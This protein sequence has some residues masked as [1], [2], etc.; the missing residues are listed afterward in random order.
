VPTPPP[1]APRPIP[2]SLAAAAA[3]FLIAGSLWPRFFVGGSESTSIEAG[4][5]RL[6]LCT[7][8]G[9]R[10]GGLDQLGQSSATWGKLG[11]AAAVLALLAAAGQIGLAM[12]A[13]RGRAAPWP[14]AAAFVG[15]LAL[16]LG[17]AFAATEPGLG[18]TLGPAAILYMVGAA[19]AITG[20]AWLH[21]AAAAPRDPA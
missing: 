15:M 21:R 2:T 4:L 12:S 16:A 6:S 20:G 18:L 9:C 3:A 17:V 8:S 1:T 14:R 19:L 7:D 13:A 11:M 10:A 5:W